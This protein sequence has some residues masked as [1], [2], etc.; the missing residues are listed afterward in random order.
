MKQ[1]FDVISKPELPFSD[2]FK[3]RDF[4]HLYDFQKFFFH[5]CLRRITELVIIKQQH[6]WDS[7]RDM[8]ESW[9]KMSEFLT[10]WIDKLYKIIIALTI[11]L[12]IDWRLSE[13]S[14]KAIDSIM[15]YPCNPYEFCGCIRKISKYLCVQIERELNDKSNDEVLHSD[16]NDTD[17]SAF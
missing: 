17:S 16:G 1:L 3:T 15:N 12:T 2:R 10:K 5:K 7:K 14:L 6:Y 11:F 13:L 4:C 8:I 9:A